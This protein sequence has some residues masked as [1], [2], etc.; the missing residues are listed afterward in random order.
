MADGDLVRRNST[1]ELPTA[2]SAKLK[3]G[4]QTGMADQ[5]TPDHRRDQ[6]GS[7]GRSPPPRSEISH[8]QPTGPVAN[9]TE[10]QA[11]K[12]GSRPPASMEE[13]FGDGEEKRRE[14]AL[15]ANQA[16]TSGFARYPPTV[17]GKVVAEGGRRPWPGFEDSP[18][19]RDLRYHRG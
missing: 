9:A 10:E 4:R 8:Q 7:G 6:V 1:A 5:L 18:S 3:G 17:G 19:R 15:Q 13:M 14:N 11:A 16:L 12:P 2:C